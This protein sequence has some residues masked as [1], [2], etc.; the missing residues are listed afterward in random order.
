MWQNDG[1]ENVA[2]SS[3][4]IATLSRAGVAD[5]DELMLEDEMSDGL[6]RLQLMKEDDDGET[7]DMSSDRLQQCDGSCDDVVNEPRVC[8]N[9]HEVTQHD[10]DTTVMHVVANCQDDLV[11]TASDGDA[12]TERDDEMSVAVYD[13]VRTASGGD[14]ETD[15]EVSV[16]CDDMSLMMLGNEIKEDVVD[17]RVDQQD[18]PLSSCVAHRVSDDSER[19]VD[20]DAVSETQCT[21]DDKQMSSDDS[22]HDVVTSQRFDA[23]D[24]HCDAANMTGPDA[25]SHC[26]DHSHL[27]SSVVD[28][29][30]YMCRCIFHFTLMSTVAV[31]LFIK[32]HVN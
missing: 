20:D 18:R 29:S 7:T 16:V 26:D 8:H 23:N 1:C 2:L 24:T 3:H 13:S 17:G 22:E 12:E 25:A 31:Q 11:M 5:D 6:R 15:D 9:R 10:C 28:S 30:T 14:T 4:H 21:D 19:P 27:H 32:L